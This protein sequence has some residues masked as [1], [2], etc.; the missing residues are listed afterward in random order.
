[1]KVK[2]IINLLRE[3]YYEED[4]LMIDWV[5]RRQFDTFSKGEWSHLN[6]GVWKKAVSDMEATESMIDMDYVAETI[7]NAKNEV[8]E[9]AS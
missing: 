3:A 4:E 5:D 7:E 8:S 6:I 2:N 9:G 1:M